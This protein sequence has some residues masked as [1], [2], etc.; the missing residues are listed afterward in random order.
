MWPFAYN[1]QLNSNLI[2]TVDQSFAQQDGVPLLTKQWAR[3]QFGEESYVSI[4]GL[5]EAPNN[6]FHT[7]VLR[8]LAR[9]ERR[10]PRD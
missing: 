10:T 9:L 5:A 4:L 6:M 3:S 2:E 1:P 8:D 7:T